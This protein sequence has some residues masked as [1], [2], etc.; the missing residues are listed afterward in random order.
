MIWPRKR[1]CVFCMRCMYA[2][3]FIFCFTF[4]HFYQVLKIVCFGINGI[5]GP[6]IRGA[7]THDQQDELK[8]IRIHLVVMVMQGPRM[9]GPSRSVVSK[10]KYEWQICERQKKNLKKNQSPEETGIFPF[11]AL[12]RR[13]SDCWG[14]RDR[15]WWRVTFL[16]AGI[17]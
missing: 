9:A 3:H 4:L 17:W 15:S 2:V 8:S 1:G 11:A 6:R 5:T 7:F 13:N 16:W 12:G 14:G 10:E